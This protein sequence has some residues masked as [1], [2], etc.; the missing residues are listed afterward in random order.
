[1]SLLIVFNWP[2]EIPNSGKMC[3]LRLCKKVLTLTFT[4]VWC[5]NTAIWIICCSVHTSYKWWHK[6]S[7]LSGCLKKPLLHNI[8]IHHQHQRNQWM[9]LFLNH[10]NPFYNFKHHYIKTDATTVTNIILQCYILYMEIMKVC[11]KILIIWNIGNRLSFWNVKSGTR[12]SFGLARTCRQTCTYFSAWRHC[13]WQSS[14][15]LLLYRSTS[16]GPPS[17]LFS[18]LTNTARPSHRLSAEK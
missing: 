16:N 7:F 6:T 4:R 9:N 10:I 12:D 1:M 18:S 14:N 13:A 11:N 5:W 8:V 15:V 3:F 2:A 17:L